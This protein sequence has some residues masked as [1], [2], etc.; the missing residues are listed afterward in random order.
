MT[1]RVTSH[2]PNILFSDEIN[3]IA[4]STRIAQVED[5][6]GVDQKKPKA[7]QSGHVSN[8]HGTLGP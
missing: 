3:R 1:V 6:L 7:P 8:F 5:V 4:G 2:R